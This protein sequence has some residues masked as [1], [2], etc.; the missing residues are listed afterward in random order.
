MT[1]A[2]IGM[3]V[4]GASGNFGFSAAG[5]ALGFGGS[6]ADSVTN[7]TE[8]ARRRRLQALQSAQAGIAARAGQ[9]YGAALGGGSSAYS[10]AGTALGF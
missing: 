4:S 1:M 7:E 9:G 5:Q 8:A 10:A 2:P 3:S 6:A